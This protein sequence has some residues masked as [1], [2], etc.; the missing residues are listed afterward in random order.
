MSTETPDE[1]VTVEPVIFDK[2]H[3]DDNPYDF[4]PRPQGWDRLAEEGVDPD[5]KESVT[6]PAEGSTSET[7]G[8]QE[9]PET[10][11]DAEKVNLSKPSPTS[12]PKSTSSAK[13]SPGRDALLA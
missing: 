5:P 10:P 12:G 8:S 1:A 2:F 6:A 3:D 9:N 7:D 11:A 4:R 13:T